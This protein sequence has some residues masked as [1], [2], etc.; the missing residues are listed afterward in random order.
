MPYDPSTFW[1][2]IAAT[3]AIVK[4]DKIERTCAL[5]NFAFSEEFLRK[6]IERVPAPYEGYTFFLDAS[7]VGVPGMQSV[8]I[9]GLD[10]VIL[11]P[12][13]KGITITPKRLGRAGEVYDE[14][15]DAGNAQSGAKLYSM[16][17]QRKDRHN[18]AVALDCENR[19]PFAGNDGNGDLSGV[20]RWLGQSCDSN[21]TFVSDPTGGHNG[22]RVKLNN[23][24]VVS[25]IGSLDRTAAGNDNTAS[26]VGTRAG[27]AFGVTE[28]E[29]IRVAIKRT[30]KTPSFIETEKG[31]PVSDAVVFMDEIDQDRLEVMA[32]NRSDD[33]GG[34]LFKYS[35]DM[36][37]KARVRAASVL[38]NIV[39]HPIMV[40]RLS[41]WAWG[42]VPGFWMKRDGPFPL[43][44]PQHLAKYHTLDF[45]AQLFCF[46][47]ERNALIHGPYS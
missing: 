2:S 15:V 23:G 31:E 4:T 40:L 8:P 18:K 1:P 39:T 46:N 25:T 41:T 3:R 14:A 44:A 22:V 28:L 27:R 45:H 38:N 17:K 47:P 33:L 37:G 24:T 13:A 5:N 29:L 34:N 30:V 42:H 7:D 19:I 12:A 21:G 32:N 43:A 16:V 20:M 26:W 36:I 10:T 11:D 9:F 35:G 6:G